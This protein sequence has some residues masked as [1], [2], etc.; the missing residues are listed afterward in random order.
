MASGNSGGSGSAA[1][2]QGNPMDRPTESRP[3]RY[4]EEIYA[5]DPD[6]WNFA[7]SAYER[8]KYEATVAALPKPHYARG[9][10][11]GCSIGVL[12]RMLAAR[13][14]ELLSVD[15][16]ETPL[17][18]ARTRCA[19]CPQVRFARMRLPDE[20]PAGPFDLAVLSEVLYYCTRDDIGRIARMLEGALAPGGDVVLVH[21][22]A[23]HDQPL[24]GDDAAEAFIAAAQ[25]FTRIL[26]QDRTPQ[27]RLDVLRRR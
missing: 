7:T 9:F 8:A 22:T 3:T 6:P 21:W 4:F 1:I 10:E 2:R 17:K 23:P 27:Y 11:V 25:D 14:D 24:D 18:E 5:R 19:D 26:K 15:A 13:C 20:A 12:T 16:A